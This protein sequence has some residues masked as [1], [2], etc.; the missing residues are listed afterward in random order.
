MGQDCTKEIDKTNTENFQAPSAMEALIVADQPF[1]LKNSPSKKSLVIWE[2]AND[3]KV[4]KVAKKAASLRYKDGSTY[5]GDVSA[6][7]KRHGF[8]RQEWKSGAYYEGIPIINSQD[9]GKTINPPESEITNLQ[10]F[11]FRAHG[12]VTS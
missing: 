1:H 11:Q 12:R 7:G 3:A 2:N 6:D 5:E 10:G 9:I 4:L 8:G